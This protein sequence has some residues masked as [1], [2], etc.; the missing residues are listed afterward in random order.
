MG[1]V[2]K[3][4]RKVFFMQT[5]ALLPCQLDD[6]ISEHSDFALGC[7]LGFD[8]YGEWSDDL[9]LT[10]VDVQGF[11]VSEVCRRYSCAEEVCGVLSLPFRAGFCLGFLSAFASDGF[12]DLASF[13]VALFSFLVPAQYQEEVKLGFDPLVFVPGTRWGC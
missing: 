9:P 11:V 1:F 12:Y 13:G 4:A 10:V 5:I 8:A 6:V 3:H 7:S 2:T